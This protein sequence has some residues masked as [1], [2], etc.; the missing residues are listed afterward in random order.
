M[1]INFTKDEYR[2]L[3]D[4]LYLSD[5]MMHSHEIGEKNNKHK[6]LRKKL[7]SFFKEMGADDLVEYSS[8]LKDYFELGEYDAELHEKFI[9]PYDDETFWEEL[10]DRLAR[11]DV[12]NKIGQNEYQKMDGFELAKL[13]LTASEPYENEFGKTG[14]DN[15]LLVKKSDQH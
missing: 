3:L 2:L 7:L 8:E 10:I 9:D 6:I 4:M 15:L 14:L 13:I 1:K 5:W 12:I 11:R